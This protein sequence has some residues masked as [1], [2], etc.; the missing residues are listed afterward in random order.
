MDFIPPTSGTSCRGQAPDR[1][2]SACASLLRAQRRPAQC[3][4]NCVGLHVQSPKGV[5]RAIPHV[6]ISSNAHETL[7]S[8]IG[9]I[10][11]HQTPSIPMWTLDFTGAQKTPQTSVAAT[12]SK[13]KPDLLH[14]DAPFLH[15]ANSRSRHTSD[16]SGFAANRKSKSAIPH[17]DARFGKQPLKKHRSELSGTAANS[18]S[19]PAI[20]HADGRFFFTPTFCVRYERGPSANAAYVEPAA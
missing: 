5:I 11:A 13:S 1:S 9:G 15:F 7:V 8:H 17:A 19:K 4:G 14:A 16:I 12:R 6:S 3:D 10:I 2:A 18:K 20:P